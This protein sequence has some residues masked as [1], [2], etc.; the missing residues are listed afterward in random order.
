MMWLFLLA[1]NSTPEQGLSGQQVYQRS[2]VNCHK[3]NGQ[4]IT[5]VYPP[6]AGSKWVNGDPSIPT[7][8]VL[9]GLQGE[10]VVKDVTYN[11]AMIGWGAT[12]SDENIAAVLTYIRSS[13][14]NNGSPVSAAEVKK[15]R[16][17]YPNHRKWKVSDF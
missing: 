1:C 15:I 14:G 6:L 13:W 9:H 3:S 10:I 7:R 11:S 5:N 8:I 2:C 17:A 16:D 12:L 4:G